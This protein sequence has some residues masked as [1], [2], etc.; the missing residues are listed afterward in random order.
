MTMPITT[1]THDARWTKVDEPNK[2]KTPNIFAKFHL[3]SLRSF[4]NK[5]LEHFS[6]SGRSHH[7]LFDKPKIV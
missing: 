5:D 7:C 6:S 4:C 3:M 2:P 1:T